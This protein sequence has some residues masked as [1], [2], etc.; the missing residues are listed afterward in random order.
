MRK[1]CIVTVTRAEFG[2]LY[3]LMKE[4]QEDFDL[5]LQIIATGM[6]LSPEFDMT[7]HLFLEIGRM[8]VQKAVIRRIG[9]KRE[10]GVVGIIS[11]QSCQRPP[12]RKF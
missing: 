4:I 11:L 2:L 5:E 10:S 3:W 9:I 6:H 12:Y 1:I 7:I 8:G